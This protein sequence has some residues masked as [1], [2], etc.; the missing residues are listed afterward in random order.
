MKNKALKAFKA[1]LLM[2]PLCFAE[3]AWSLAEVESRSDRSPQQN[4]SNQASE[5][6]QNTSLSTLQKIEYLQREMMELRGKLEEQGYQLQQVQEQNKKLYMDLDK[7][8][9]D[10]PT[11]AKAAGT[12]S[13]AQSEQGLDL[14]AASRFV[15][16]EPDPGLKTS[17]INAATMPANAV[18]DEK[19]YQ[20]AY[21]LLQNR[22]FDGA[23]KAFNVML[24]QS[25]Q[26]KYA[27]N[28]H[29]WLGEIHLTK[30]NLEKAAE[31]FNVVY[32]QYPQHPKAADSLLKLGYVEYKKGQWKRSK[33]LLNQVKSQYPGTTSAQLADSRLQRM[34]QE[35]HI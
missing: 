27:P 26:G 17:T 20:T 2:L 28:A 35:G 3:V 14:N 6:E 29:Y 31:D 16:E 10:S 22:D 21:R 12:S 11:A 7:R 25:P 8:L 30:G 18:N 19:A 1:F 9:R 13:T 24:E 23:V 33:E 32:R 34:Q 15:S 4:W 5:G